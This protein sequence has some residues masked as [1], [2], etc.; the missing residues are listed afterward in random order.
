MPAPKLVDIAPGKFGYL[1]QRADT[2]MEGQITFNG[3]GIVNVNGTISGTLTVSDT[4]HKGEQRPG[5]YL[6]EQDDVTLLLHY[7]L[8]Q[9]PG[10]QPTVFGPWFTAEL[11]AG[12]TKFDIE[13]EDDTITGTAERV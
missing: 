5:T 2:V 11:V 4:E 1:L 8:P 3:D 7:H 13:D 12:G 6:V 9:G 10:A